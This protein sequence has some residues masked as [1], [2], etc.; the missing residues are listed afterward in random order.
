MYEYYT[1]F[2]PF[3]SIKVSGTDVSCLVSYILTSNYVA[4]MGFLSG[5]CAELSGFNLSKREQKKLSPIGCFLCSKGK[6]LCVFRRMLKLMYEGF[7]PNSILDA[8]R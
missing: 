7:C 6:I 4:C 3:D 5:F 8:S 2:S 1:P